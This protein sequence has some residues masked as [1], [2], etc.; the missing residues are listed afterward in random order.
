MVYDFMRA[1]FSNGIHGKRE[2]QQQFGNCL[3]YEIAEVS[4]PRVRLRFLFPSLKNLSA[5]YTYAYYYPLLLP[6]AWV[7]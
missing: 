5:Y 2:A 7:H 4:S 3:A 1:I 6:I